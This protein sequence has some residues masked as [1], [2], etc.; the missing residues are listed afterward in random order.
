MWPN[1]YQYIWCEDIYLVCL[2]FMMRSI[3]WCAY[4]WMLD[5]YDDLLV[6][7]MW[8]NICVTIILVTY[9]VTMCD[10]ICVVNIICV[11][12]SVT[13]EVISGIWCVI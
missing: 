2:Y 10:R 1:D 8:L 3:I 7:M 9:I 6:G 11:T 12:I 4:Y 5:W 13:Y